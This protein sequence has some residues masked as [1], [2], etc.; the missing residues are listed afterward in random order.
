MFIVLL[1]HSGSMG[2]PFSGTPDLHSRRLRGAKAEVKLA[3]AKEVLLEELANLDAQVE[4]V[5]FSFTGIVQLAFAG[6]AGQRTEIRTA[7][8]RLSAE[9][10]TDIAAALTAAV[11]HKTRW[12]GAGATSI[13]LISDG[14]SDRDSALAAA[15]RC[16][17]MG[18]AIH[19]ILID[20][21]DEGHAFLRHVI[22][23]VGGTSMI[24]TSRSQ[25]RETARQARAAHATAQ[26]RADRYLQRS[27]AESE[28]IAREVRN[29][30]PLEFTAGYPGQIEPTVSYPLLVYVH[31]REMRTEVA[32]RLAE[33]AP[34]LGAHPRASDV[35]PAS[36]LVPIGTQLDVTP[37]I[38]N[39]VVAPAQQRVTWLGDL[40][41]LTFRIRYSEVESPK[42]LCSGFI[43]IGVSGLLIARIP[44]SIAFTSDL[45]E[46][47]IQQVTAEMI[48]RVF[49]SYSRQDLPV[50]RACKATYRALGIQLFIDKEEL[51][52]GV[53]WE[54]I[55]RQSIASHDL[56][57][58][59]WSRAS[60]DSDYV[61]KEWK[62]ALSLEKQRA[63]DFVRP[64]Y[65]T[66]P[67]VTPPAAL[68]HIN[69]GFLDV[70]A[71]NVP[72]ADQTGAT[73]VGPQ[74]AWK[75]AAADF[76]ILPVVPCNERD[77]AQLRE[78]LSRTAPFLEHVLGVRYYPPATFVVDEHI[79]QALQ[80]VPGPA[81]D[82]STA[83]VDHI[84]NVLQSLALAFHVGRLAEDNSRDA[85]EPFWGLKDPQERA[86][87]EHVVC[88]AEWV[89]QGPTREY[90]AGED[91]WAEHLRPLAEVLR[92]EGTGS[93][94]EYC[95]DDLL[96]WLRESAQGEDRIVVEDVVTDE[97]IEALAPYDG[98]RA[99]VAQQ[100]LATP[101]SDLAAKY[102]VML[103]FGRAARTELRFCQGFAEY[104]TAYCE[105]WLRYVDL[106]FQKRGEVVIDV[107]YSIPE[108]TFEWLRD[109]LP[110]IGVIVKNKVGWRDDENQ[111]NYRLSLVDYRNCV[112]EL[113]GRLRQILDNRAA[114]SRGRH[115][116]SVA[117][118]TFGIFIPAG[119]ERVHAQFEQTLQRAGWPVSAGL[120]GQPKVLVCAD[121]RHRLEHEISQKIRVRKRAEDLARRLM[122]AVLVHEH[123][124]AAL[125]GGLDAQGLPAAAAQD[126]NEW[127]QGNALN[128]S[129]AAWAEL[130]YFR[131]DPEMAEY[132]TA[133]IGSGEYPDWPYRGAGTI[134]RFFDHGGLPEVR[135]WI[136]RLRID[137][138]NAQREFDRSVDAASASAGGPS[139]S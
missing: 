121:A 123:F 72:A 67:M 58:L 59:F 54:D 19:F 8:D 4:L 6:T 114:F 34:H 9:D 93:Q 128:E 82:D 130:H 63:R 95:L 21:T 64:V 125:A 102:G 32:R 65:W 45:A 36:K 81:R 5:I 89:F 129:L 132:V 26:A 127:E 139:K 86:E 118:S 91:V 10:G 77:L 133:Y 42:N 14:K 117:A 61:A 92:S 39:V 124:H 27:H 131:E 76:P 101:V 137:P 51:L 44:V 94:K 116:L 111:I 136:R 100:L 43:D 96:K 97:V 112:A 99:A 70:R 50:V 84:L 1:D 126:L 122:A 73:P 115:W 83:M 52:P 33:A 103:F 108:A 47:D 60:A 53:P 13:M 35:A 110:D 38:S 87:F 7:L 16:S 15:T 135:A 90:L 120:R 104:V 107:G 106:A 41:E 37:R 20:R 40:E 98:A 78:A 55:I 62:L 138:F 57:Q 113:S 56:F 23:R 17:E 29:K 88:M 11:E 79:V 105:R 49:G 22:G 18:V 119:A 80:A 68:A 134:E 75:S 25:L 71:L 28:S 31:L 69:F 30:E 48:S 74:S 46:L 66:E 109:E 3:A 85:E 2:Q 12:G 24:V